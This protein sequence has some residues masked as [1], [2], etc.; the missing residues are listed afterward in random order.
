MKDYSK[1]KIY[2][3]VCNISGLTYIGSTCEP[4]LARRLTKH[5]RKFKCWKNGKD[6]YLS[7]FKV[8]EG[9]NYDIIL[10]ESFPCQNVDEL[11]QRERFHIENNICVNN[12]VPIKT[13]EERQQYAQE[14]N[15]N[16]REEN[17]EYYKEYSKNFYEKNQHYINIRNTENYI[18]NKSKRLEKHVC[19]CGKTYTFEHKK[20]HE[21][22]IFHQS[23]MNTIV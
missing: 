4:T 13:Q 16:Y 12:K 22:T 20:R 14:Y 23:R 17:K 15:K 9:D 2:R 6:T 11:F 3:I 8:I 19:S 1:G 7:S 18:K 5:V 10:V 21:K